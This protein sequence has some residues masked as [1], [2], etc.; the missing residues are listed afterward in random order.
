M[1]LVLIKQGTHEWNWMWEWLASHPI[2]EGIEEPSIATHEGESWQY[3]GSYQQGNRVLHTFRHRQHPRYNK[4][5]TVSVS[6]SKDFTP[7]QIAKNFKI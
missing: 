7:D 5:E 3:M 4:V 6:A 2:N 1:E